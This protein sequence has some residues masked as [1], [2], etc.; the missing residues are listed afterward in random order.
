MDTNDLQDKPLTRL[1]DAL[2]TL[3][4]FIGYYWFGE[5]FELV[6]VTYLGIIAYHSFAWTRTN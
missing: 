6:V 1:L 2:F 3:L 5:P 4:P